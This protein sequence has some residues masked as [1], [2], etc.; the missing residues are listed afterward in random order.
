MR[1]RVLLIYYAWDDYALRTFQM[2]TYF[3]SPAPGAAMCRTKTCVDDLEQQDYEQV[4]TSFLTGLYP[5][6]LNGAACS[7]NGNACNQALIDAFTRGH[8]RP[9]YTQDGRTIT[10]EDAWGENVV[11][12]LAWDETGAFSAHNSSDVNLD[13]CVSITL[14]K[15][16]ARQKILCRVMTIL[17]RVVRHPWN[18]STCII[19]RPGVSRVRLFLKRR[20]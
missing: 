16:G 10:F 13:A 9:P 8:A 17:L 15:D 3:Q 14:S 5:S 7:S 18:A 1:R 19:T 6:E 20:M 12:V 11:L 4:C 2:P